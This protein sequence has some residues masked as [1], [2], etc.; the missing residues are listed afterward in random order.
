MATACVDGSWRTIGPV[1]YGIVQDGA[2]STM[3]F[4]VKAGTVRRSFGTSFDL[5]LLVVGAAEA[6]NQVAAI[7]LSL[8]VK[9]TL[10]LVVLRDHPS[11]TF[12]MK[13]PIDE[14][15]RTK[16]VVSGMSPG[17]LLSTGTGDCCGDCAGPVEAGPEVDLW[18][19]PD[20][21]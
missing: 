20:G 9:D 15:Y 4:S 11:G 12:T 7:V 8:S 18:P 6:L 14:G 10:E 13:C 5:A 19:P 3:C 16:W 1:V 21:G 2:Q 17:G